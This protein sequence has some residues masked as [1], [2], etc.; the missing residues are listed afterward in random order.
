MNG[1]IPEDENLLGN[2]SDP[3]RE[4]MERTV[5]TNLGPFAVP[6]QPDI[7]VVLK[8]K[9]CPVPMIGL[10]DQ[11]ELTVLLDPEGVAHRGFVGGMN[12][13]KV[14]QIARP[15]TKV[16]KAFYVLGVFKPKKE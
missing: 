2:S 6:N 12:V 1:L 10:F 4:V 8:F 3:D 9:P 5:Q 14:E 11:D 15:G 7:P 13:M 16:D